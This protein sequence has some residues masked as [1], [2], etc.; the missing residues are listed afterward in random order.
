MT[1]RVGGLDLTDPTS[2]YRVLRRPVAELLA[3]NGFPRGLTESSLLIDLHRKGFRIGEVPVSMRAPT[4][5]SM[6]RGLAGGR[7]LMRIS[8]AVLVQSRSR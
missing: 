2:G 6:H 5:H 3:A 8:W 4:G 7:Q 1:A